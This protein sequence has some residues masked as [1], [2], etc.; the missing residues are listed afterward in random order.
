M[1]K[2]MTG[3]GRGK[4]QAD[5]ME[6]LVEIKTVNHRYSD[7]YIKIPRQIA[8]LE[9]KVREAISKSISRGKVDVFISF[10]DFSEDSK[11]ILIDEGL[12]KTYISAVQQLR[13]KYDLQD[14]I[15]VSLIAKFP[16]VLKVEKVEQDEE[17]IWKVLG[18]ALNTAIESL[19]CM[20]QIEGEGL[21]NSILEKTDYIESIVKDIE[22]RAPEVVKEYKC[23]LENRIKEILDQQVVDENRLATEVAIF[24]DR[25]SIDEELVRLKSH[26]NQLRE[27]LQTGQSVGRKLDF[28]IQEMNREINTIGS[29][30][31]DLSIS[32][33][34]VEIKSELEKIREQVQ[35]IE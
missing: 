10:E 4:S 27:T 14:D 13:D 23:R 34:V 32:K 26:I 11:S 12:A 8:F 7:I 31:N 3:F 22:I 21:K 18:E 29:K 24:A 9:D 28:L 17:K 1:I 19:V 5:G 20:R 35:N 15:S 30:A 6:C 25:C 33:L 2:S 16:D